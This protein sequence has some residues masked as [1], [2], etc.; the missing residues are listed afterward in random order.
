MG[1]FPFRPPEKKGMVAPVDGNTIWPI[2][3]SPPDGWF[4]SGLESTKNTKGT[5][6]LMSSAFF[7]R[8]VDERGN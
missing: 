7:V 6:I 1:A 5:N 8:F 3:V 4:F 2:W